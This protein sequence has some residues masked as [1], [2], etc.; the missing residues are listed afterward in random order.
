MTAPVFKML[1]EAGRDDWLAANHGIP[2]AGDPDLA[3]LDHDALIKERFLGEANRGRIFGMPVAFADY[4]HVSVLRAENQAFQ[5]WK[6]E[7]DW[8]A[9]PGDV[10]T[11]NTGAIAA[12]A[13][14]IPSAALALTRGTP[15][16]GE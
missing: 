14:L 1:S 10:T 12:E 2:P 11:V 7:T 4:P 5:R 3:I 13:G 9:R 8:G 16:S 15:V 6:I